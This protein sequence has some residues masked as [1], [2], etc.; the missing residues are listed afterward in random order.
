MTRRKAYLFVLALLLAGL[1]VLLSAAALQIWQEGSARKAQNPLAA[2]YTP[3][4]VAAQLLRIRPLALAVIGMAAAGLLLGIRDESSTRPVPSPEA[5]RSLLASQLE[6]P[7]EAVRRERK[8]QRSL[9]WIRRAAFAAC[10]LPA[11]AYCMDRAHFPAQDLEAMLASLVLHTLPWIAAG[12]GVLLIGALLEEKSIRREIE[13]ARAQL[14]AGKGGRPAAVG[15]PPARGAGAIRILLLLA[16]GV[17]IVLGALNGSLE[18]VLRKAINIC[19]EC[20][21]LG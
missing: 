2:V 6:M 3:E 14:R 4:N 16:A 11:L 19:T 20:I 18:D 5:E 10:L 1:T 8:R 17:L 13:A 21:G 15:S 12:L 7:G 9:R